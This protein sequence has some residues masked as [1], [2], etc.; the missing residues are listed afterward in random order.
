MRLFNI[1]DWR[2]ESFDH[3]TEIPPYIAISHTWDRDEIV[4]NDLTDL[5]SATQRASFSKLRNA[6]RIA[7]SLGADWIWIDTVCINKSSSAELTE[8]INSSFRWFRDS[9][10]CVVYLRDLTSEPTANELDLNKLALDRLALYKLNLETSLRSCGWMRRSW[11]LQELIAPASVRFYDS[12]W[13]FVG[14]KKSLSCVLSRITQ[15]D[16]RVLQNEECLP[17][18]SVGVRMSWASNRVAFRVEDIAYSLIGIFDVSMPIIYG[19]G[20]RSFL[21]LQEEI[22]KVTDDATLFAWQANS[23]QKY[24]GLFAHSPSEFSHFTTVSTNKP[25]RIHGAVCVTSSGITIESTFG[26]HSPSKALIFGILLENKDESE[27]TC[28]GVLLRP[29]DHCYV[30]YSP[31]T[32]L[33]LREFPKEILAKVVIKRDILPRTFGIIGMCLSFAEVHNFHAVQTVE[34]PSKSRSVHQASTL[35]QAKSRNVLPLPVSR[36]QSCKET[37]YHDR[38][39]CMSSTP[40]AKLG[41][42]SC[43]GV[44]PTT[45]ETA[46]REEA[47]SELYDIQYLDVDSS[48]SLEEIDQESDGISSDSDKM[49]GFDKHPYGNSMPSIDNPFNHVLGVLTR[50]ALGN[51]ISDIEQ[52]T[53]STGKRAKHSSPGSARKRLRSLTDSSIELDQATDSDDEETVLVNYRRGRS[54]PAFACPYYRRNPGA[55]HNCLKRVHLRQINDIKQHILRDHRRPPFCPVCRTTFDSHALCNAHIAERGCTLKAADEVEGVSY[56]QMKALTKRSGPGL[57]A[58]QQWFVIWDIVFPN[59]QCPEDVFLSG[60]VESIVCRVREYWSSNGKQVIRKFLSE[61]NMGHFAVD[62]EHAAGLEWLFSEIL[63]QLTDKIVDGLD[64]TNGG[65]TTESSGKTEEVLGRL[66]RTCIHILV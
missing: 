7:S 50:F 39:T 5:D 23:S 17:E 21:R 11:T 18:Y 8:A 35:A 3:P 60:P 51:F 48:S 32:T 24:R 1:H 26:V 42:I 61:N 15:I 46:Q 57:S 10:A 33:Q 49:A 55:H 44:V 43:S 63:A 47:E 52:D 59:E 64:L 56:Y 62:D 14:T 16:E 2:L 12:K 19:E 22:L 6:G 53:P 27:P 28:L 9:M 40:L 66:R 25:S 41:E 30:R 45:K 38:P 29:W 65:D 54:A 36:L 37:Y 20:E 31:Q 4:Y 13:K 58:E 34:T